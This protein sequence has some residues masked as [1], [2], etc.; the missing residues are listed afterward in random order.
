MTNFME[1]LKNEALNE[2]YNVAYSENGAR[3]YATTGKSLL[4]FSFK[5]SNYRAT[6]E[7]SITKDFEKAWLE[8]PDYALKYLLSNP[9]NALP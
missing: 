1:N 3:G 8:M 5:L 4:D 2:E 7:L 6:N 9:S